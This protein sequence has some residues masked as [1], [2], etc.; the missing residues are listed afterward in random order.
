MAKKAAAPTPPL[1][2]KSSASKTVP[3]KAVNNKASA[4]SK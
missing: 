4:T 1:S 2:K 3:A